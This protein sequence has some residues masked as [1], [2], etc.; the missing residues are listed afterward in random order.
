VRSGLRALTLAE[1]AATIAAATVR[2]LSYVAVPPEY[3]I[4]EL[5]ERGSPRAGAWNG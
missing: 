1:A 5:V 2:P 4:A 3:F